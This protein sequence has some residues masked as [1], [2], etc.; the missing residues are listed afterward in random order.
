MMRFGWA[1]ILAAGGLVVL[2]GLAV[3]FAGLSAL[4]AI[5]VGV[6]VATMLCY[7]YDKCQARVGGR[8]VP[9][10]ALHVLAVVG[11]TPGA[12]IGQLV[13]RHKTRDRLFRVVFFAIAAVQVVVLLTITHVRSS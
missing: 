8:R 13:F 5:F 3:G 9:E 7:G 6:N 10:V 4:R 1:A 2:I 12:F 11:G